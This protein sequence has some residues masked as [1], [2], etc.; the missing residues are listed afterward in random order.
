MLPNPNPIGKSFSIYLIFFSLD[1]ELKSN[2]RG[3]LSSVVI[4]GVAD[5]AQLSKLFE[6][7]P[8]IILDFFQ[9]L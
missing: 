3:Q 7:R 6:I 1:I 5:E 9:Y 4:G 8:S 2:I